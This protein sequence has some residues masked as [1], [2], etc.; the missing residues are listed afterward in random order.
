MS[1]SEQISILKKAMRAEKKQLQT[2]PKAKAKK[3][4]RT[5]LTKIGVLDSSGKVSK[6]YSRGFAN[7]Q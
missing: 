6:N 4:A 7:A 3:A 1:T 5:S 2:M